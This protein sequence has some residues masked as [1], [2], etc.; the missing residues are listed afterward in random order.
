MTRNRSPLVNSEPT[1]QPHPTLGV[2]LPVLKDGPGPAG[3]LTSDSLSA[4]VGAS[5]AS[6]WLPP[7]ATVC[8]RMFL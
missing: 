4:P 5:A 1:P 6:T 7:P 3:L 2:R 8:G